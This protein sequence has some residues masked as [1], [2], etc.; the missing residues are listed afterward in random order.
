MIE[1]VGDRKEFSEGGI[2]FS[3]LSV[4]QLRL[5]YRRYT[6]VDGPS[7]SRQLI[8]ELKRLIKG[9]DEDGIPFNEGG[10]AK[11]A[12]GAIPFIPTAIAAARPFAG[13]LLRKGAEVIGGTALG[14]RLS[15]TFFSK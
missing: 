11:L 10:R 8:R 4:P 1:G 2:D 5:L 12:V 15:D 13:P 9:L 7:D 6:G 14:K 3:G